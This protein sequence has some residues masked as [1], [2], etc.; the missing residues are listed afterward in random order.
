MEPTMTSA[1]TH[2]LEG[3]LKAVPEALI[4]RDV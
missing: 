2:R 4:D 1:Q 3:T